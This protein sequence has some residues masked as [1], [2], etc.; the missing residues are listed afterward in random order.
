MDAN[1]DVDEI[2]YREGKPTTW[3]SL[4]DITRRIVRPASTLL[5]GKRIFTLPVLFGASTTLQTI[6]PWILDQ[7]AINISGESHTQ[8]QMLSS[9]DKE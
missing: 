8:H 3:R 7:I 4:G 9:R 2:I 1:S 6:S 5:S